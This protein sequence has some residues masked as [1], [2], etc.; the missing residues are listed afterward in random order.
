MKATRSM[1]WMLELLRIFDYSH[2]KRSF[3]KTKLTVIHAYLLR[4]LERKRPCNAHNEAEKFLKEGWR[5]YKHCLPAKSQAAVPTKHKHSSAVSKREIVFG[6]PYLLAH[7]S[8][9]VRV[10]CYPDRSQWQ[11]FNTSICIYIYIYIYF[12]Y[13]LQNIT[14]ITY[15]VKGG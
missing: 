3:P 7:L 5:Q 9:T 12:T 11:Y 4:H 14:F 6:R 10:T 8:I 2:Y 15:F 13:P 1:C